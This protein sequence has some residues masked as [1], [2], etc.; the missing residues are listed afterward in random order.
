M[1]FGP[2]GWINGDNF[3]RSTEAFG[4]LPLPEQQCEKLGMLVYNANFAKMMKSRRE[5]L[6]RKQN[7]QMAVL[8]V[9]TKFERML[10]KA[11]ILSLECIGKCEPGWEALAQEWNSHCDGKDIFYKVR[12]SGY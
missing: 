2:G 7:T 12:R 11:L 3:L 10:F 1:N 6:V 4:I 5:Y 9:H 8:P